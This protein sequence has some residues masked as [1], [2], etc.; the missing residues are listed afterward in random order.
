MTMMEN[1]DRTAERWFSCQIQMS[2]MYAVASHT[3]HVKCMPACLLLG[4]IRYSCALS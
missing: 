4:M 1:V 3:K 2:A